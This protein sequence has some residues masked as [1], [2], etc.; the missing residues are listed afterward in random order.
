MQV[1][2]ER[3]PTPL[4]KKLNCKMKL[5]NC[6]RVMPLSAV[7]ER[8]TASHLHR[9]VC[10]ILFDFGGCVLIETMQEHLKQSRKGKQQLTLWKRS[11][12]KLLFGI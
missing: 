9:F 1:Q 7:S 2:V 5:P 11:H 12:S 4:P 3:T 6:S 10:D 8:K